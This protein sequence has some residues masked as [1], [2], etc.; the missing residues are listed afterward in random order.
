[1]AVL[2]RIFRQ[3]TSSNSNNVA[4]LQKETTEQKLKLGMIV[5]QLMP[6]VAKSEESK[7]HRRWQQFAEQMIAHVP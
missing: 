1:M 5:I 3:V 4:D 7:M 6:V 2:K